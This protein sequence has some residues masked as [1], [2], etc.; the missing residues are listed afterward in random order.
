MDVDDVADVAGL[1]N[2][3][4]VAAPTVDT[5]NMRGFTCVDGYEDLLSDELL[6]T[7]GLAYQVDW[8]LFVCCKTMFHSTGIFKHFSNKHTR[9]ELPS[10]A[11]KNH[12]LQLIKQWNIPDSYVDAQPTIAPRMAASGIPIII[13]DLY[14]CPHC[15][16]TGAKPHVNKHNNK[17]PHP[18]LPHLPPIK[19]PSAQYVNKTLCRVTPRPKP[20]VEG[21]TSLT[22]Q[23]TTY[24]T[25]IGK[26]GT[27]T[28]ARLISPFLNRTKWHEI[29]EPYKDH[30]AE[31]IEL[32]TFP[33]K[34]KFQTLVAAVRLYFQTADGLFDHTEELV[35]QHLNT[36][37]PPKNGINNTPFHRHHMG[38]A[39]AH[40]YVTIVIRLLAS[41]LRRSEVFSMEPGEDVAAAINELRLVLQDHRQNAADAQAVLHTV[42]TTL[43][44]TRWHQTAASRMPDPTMR[45]LM[46]MSSQPN[47]E[48]AAPT[49]TSQPI[50]KLCWGI[51]MHALVE[52]HRIVDAEGIFQMEAFKRIA[53]F[54]IE[55]DTTTYATLWSLQHYV[56]TLCNKTV[57][58]PK[59]W[60]I[61]TDNWSKL[62]YNGQK[63]T[64]AQ[65]RDVF[66]KLEAEVID[67][68]EVAVLMGLNLHITWSEIVDDLTE[69]RA[70]YSFLTDE[71]NE[72]HRHKH[73]FAKALD[74][75]AELG[76]KFT[77]T[78]SGYMQLDMIKCRDWLYKLAKLEGLVMLLTDMLG[79]AP[80]RGTELVS[81]LACNTPLRLRNFAALGK[82]IAL[83]RQYDKTSNITQCD[84]LIPHSISAVAADILV[85][86]HTFARPWAQ[87][88][89]SKIWPTDPAV[90]TAYGDMLFMDVGRMFTSR[91]LSELMGN[92]TAKPVGWEV[93]LSP[94][95]Q[96][97][98]AYRRKLCRGVAVELVEQET[99]STL[100]AMHSGHSARTENMVYGLSP[101]SLAG[102][103]EDVLP[104]FLHGS[105][106]WQQLN[107]IVPGGLGLD[108]RAARCSNFAELVLSG[109][110]KVRGEKIE[111]NVQSGESFSLM[112]DQM[113]DLRLDITGK[114]DLAYDLIGQIHSRDNEV[115]AAVTQ[116]QAKQDRTLAVLALIEARIIKLEGEALQTAKQ[117]T[118]SP[119]KM[120]VDTP[121]PIRTIPEKSA[122]RTS[123]PYSGSA[124]PESKPENATS[125]P[126][127]VN[128][129]KQFSPKQLK[130]GPSSPAISCITT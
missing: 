42:F 50:R 1:H 91:R 110:I 122:E 31:L 102:A 124:N 85:Q 7:V 95:R 109:I 56:T 107:E 41:L 3:V 32:A 128:I 16:L 97:N 35:L 28:N 112:V 125:S 98:I 29:R 119:Q 38:D 25:N 45:F 59:I 70:G 73:A 26:G 53:E 61:D 90:S 49:S 89:A 83:I 54:V 52:I 69:N 100:N 23:M 51:Q 86:I 17:N 22:E 9:Q 87:F 12:I 105:G 77:T 114:Q 94:W 5:R 120:D 64:L 65:I 67:L 39:T 108:Y 30:V 55:K 72:F 75:D 58:F 37:D 4:P 19:V 34:D 8:N 113:A 80:P 99:V 27:T 14:G 93:T 71:R 20:V 48:F 117:K 13:K 60:W 127:K 47:G 121:S 101:D 57:S 46:L 84:R 62:L 81:M 74:H 24:N 40:H 15:P 33:A 111:R 2:H 82:H 130:T 66:I 104:L 76:K 103:P 10:T 88:L 129:I 63:I 123:P 96:V 18:S 126:T 21:V 115:I 78:A 116:I 106:E 43:W 6:D 118:P 44:H 11:V 36:H 92:K 68:W 79:G